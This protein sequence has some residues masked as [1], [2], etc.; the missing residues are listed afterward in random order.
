MGKLLAID[1]L[2]IVRRLYEASDEEDAGLRTD[3]VLRHASAAFTRLL[4]SHQ[5]THA[6]AAFDAGGHT[7]RHTLHAS[8]RQNRKPM[9]DE[10]QHALPDLFARLANAGLQVVSVAGVEADDVIATSVLRWLQEARGE[11][12]IVS[13][14]KD[15]HGLIAHGA[16]VWDHF[17][18]EWHDEAWVQ[19]KFG[20]P[21][22]LLPDLLAL[23]GDVPDGIPG[24]S[25]IGVKTAAKLLQSYGS[26][27][28]IMAGAGILK[29][30]LGERLRNEREQLKL[31]R[32][33]T[34]L[35]ADVR[36]GVTWN[37]LACTPQA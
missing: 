6:L 2:N 31:S 37:M 16:L 15:L 9:P 14:D 13:T 21:P 29:D 26:I 34:A 18:N 25:K 24:V 12:I 4:S 7:W 19:A 32:E 27:D 30:A 11:A 17:K 3:K 33:L 22:D 8:Y 36:L 1:G 28:G 10:L 23:V 5:P 20:V 35:K